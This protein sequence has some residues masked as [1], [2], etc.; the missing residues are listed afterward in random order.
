MLASG[1]HSRHGHFSGVVALDGAFSEVG[2]KNLLPPPHEKS[3]SPVTPHKGTKPP[4]L[5]EQEKKTH[6]CK[7]D[8][9]RFGKERLVAQWRGFGA[10]MQS[11]PAQSGSE[12]VLPG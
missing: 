7:R 11:L 4:E 10:M 2:H 8:K 5:T 6:T 1:Q 3:N 9:S 12:L